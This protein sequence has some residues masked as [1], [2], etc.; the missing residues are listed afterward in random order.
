VRALAVAL[1][2]LCRTFPLS[3]HLP[4]TAAGPE[5]LVGD[6]SALGLDDLV[7]HPLP[8]RDV[9][10]D[11]RVCWDAHDRP[12]LLDEVPHLL[13]RPLAEDPAFGNRSGGSI[14]SSRD[15]PCSSGSRGGREGRV[16]VVTLVTLVTLVVTIVE[17]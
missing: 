12:G 16:V 3:V 7:A 5:V 9:L 1:A 15:S 17:T 10:R 13:G 4:R 2:Q 8:P 6:D 11:A 14:S